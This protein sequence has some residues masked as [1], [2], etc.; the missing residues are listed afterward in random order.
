MSSFKD[1]K[2]LLSRMG[3]SLHGVRCVKDQGGGLWVLCM[4]HV[5][6]RGDGVTEIRRQCVVVNG[7]LFLCT[8][9]SA[10]PYGLLPSSYQ[11]SSVPLND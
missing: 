9:G 10:R 6:G 4:G 5:R 1:V 7:R 3:K 2:R 8:L 11:A